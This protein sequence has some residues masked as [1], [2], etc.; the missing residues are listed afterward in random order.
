M[1]RREF[2]SL[3]G[4]G[5]VVWPMTARAQPSNVARI[6]VLYI[7]LADAE[8]FRK[9]LREGLRELGYVEGQNIAMARKLLIALWR[10]VTTGEVPAGV[11][12]RA[13]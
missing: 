11:V 2:I 5:A 7:G 10:L 8:S 9:E 12:L 13:A 4:V 6:G 1:K 3:L